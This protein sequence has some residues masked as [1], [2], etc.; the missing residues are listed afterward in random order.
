MY[1]R[2]HKFE[3]EQVLPIDLARA[4]AFFSSPGN[5]SIIT[6]PEMEFKILTN[7]L[8]PEIYNG[9]IID[10]RVKPLAGIPMKWRTEIRN[11]THLKTFTDIQLIGPYKKW[12]HTHTFTACEEGVLMKDEII[13][14]L[15]FGILGSLAHRMMIKNK[16]EKIFLYRRSVLLKL[17]PD[18]RHRV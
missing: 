12:E 9:M 8:S 7:N 4:W 6:P 18:E 15:P 3:A 16:I 11:V 17:F 10:Y 14:M 13:Y 1:T 2:P 5:L